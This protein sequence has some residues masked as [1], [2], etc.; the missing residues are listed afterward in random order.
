MYGAVIDHRASSKKDPASIYG[1][2]VSS[3]DRNTS[4]TS[5]LQ[6]SYA[7]H[8]HK[9][10]TATFEEIAKESFEHVKSKF[11]VNG[12]A[13]EK[14][15]FEDREYEMFLSRTKSITEH[16]NI[17]RIFFA[18][19]N[20]ESVRSLRTMIEN[21]K[22]WNEQEI[23]DKALMLK[24][25]D[26]FADVVTRENKFGHFTAS[27][28]VVDEDCS[29]ALMLHHNIM[30]DWIYPGGHADGEYDLYSV[31]LREVQEETGLTVYP[32]FDKEIFAIQAAPVKGHIKNGK[33]V[34]AHIHYDVLFVFKAKK[35]DMNKIRIL[36]N[37]NKSVE[38]WDI[39]DTFTN[40]NVVGW[41]IP[42]NRKI[43]QKLGY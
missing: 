28:F 19:A 39:C 37:E 36:A 32:M 30:N 25:I 40:P 6:R 38:W 27:A 20:N 10:P 12:Y 14:M 31:A 9:N 23:A 43:V 16:F 26:T 13:S 41:A 24:F 21:Y 3:A 4:V 33:Y 34:P 42:V 7:Y 11:G 2:I 29:K 18:E 22:P 1:K 17:Y 35:E 8:K 5:I 15:Y